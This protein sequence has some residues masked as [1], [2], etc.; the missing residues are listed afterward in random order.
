MRDKI[1]D[2]SEDFGYAETAW[3]ILY[4]IC[5]AIKT[6]NDSLHGGCND[7]EKELLPLIEEIVAL[8][9]LTQIKSECEFKELK[10]IAQKHDCKKLLQKNY[11]NGKENLRNILSH[12][13]CY[14]AD[15]RFE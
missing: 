8:F 2:C 10:S 5:A 3:N 13:K 4:N 7:K 15:I 12:Q 6:K 1:Y 14:A 11:Q 9:D